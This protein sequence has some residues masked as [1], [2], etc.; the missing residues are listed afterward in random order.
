MSTRTTALLC[1]LSASLGGVATW[2][3]TPRPPPC[4]RREELP[5]GGRPPPRR[6][7]SR[8]SHGVPRGST[9]GGGH[10]LAA[11]GRP[12]AMRAGLEPGAAVSGRE[13]Q[14]PAPDGQRPAARDSRLFGPVRSRRR[15]T[16]PELRLPRKREDRCGPESTAVAGAGDILRPRVANVAQP[17]AEARVARR[18][19]RQGATRRDSGLRAVTFDRRGSGVSAGLLRRGTGVLAETDD[20]RLGGGPAHHQRSHR[21]ARPV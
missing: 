11:A 18:G 6:P 7:F 8:R 21:Q 14:E 17:V 15:R 19:V 12:E 20:P 13:S 2:Q 16:A 4:P 10:R 3:F 9:A 5:R 1:L